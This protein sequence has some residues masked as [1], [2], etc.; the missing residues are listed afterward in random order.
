MLKEKLVIPVI[1]PETDNVKT[2]GITS[3]ALT[4]APSLFQERVR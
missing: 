2:A 1:D 4:W 3:P